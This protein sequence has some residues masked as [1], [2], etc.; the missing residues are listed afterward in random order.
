[1]L[2]LL[3]QGQVTRPVLISG[4]RLAACSLYTYQLGT[5][6]IY[7]SQGRTG[8]L[9]NESLHVWLHVWCWP[10][11]MGNTK[12]GGRYVTTYLLPKRQDAK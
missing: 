1:M 5:L 3:G 12:M 9:D 8:P 11:G 7:P 2:R 6:Y 4:V 10:W